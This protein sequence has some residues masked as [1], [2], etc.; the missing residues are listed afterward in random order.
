MK[1]VSKERINSKY[2]KKYD[3]PKTPYQRLIASEYISEDCKQNLT[4]TFLSLNP[5]TLKKKIESK[6]KIIFNTLDNSSL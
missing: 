4:D 5:F 6:L 3:P 1:L 2:V